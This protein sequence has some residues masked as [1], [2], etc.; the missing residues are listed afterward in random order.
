MSDV[1]A[2]EIISY[3]HDSFPGVAVVQFRLAVPDVR[4]FENVF[5][6]PGAPNIGGIGVKFENKFGE[7]CFIPGKKLF[8][9]Q[10]AFNNRETYLIP[11][12]KSTLTVVFSRPEEGTHDAFNFADDGGR[13]EEN[14]GPV[15]GGDVEDGSD[16]LHSAGV[17]EAPCTPGMNSFGDLINKGLIVSNAKTFCT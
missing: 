16:E 10:S 8:E 12:N 9:A 13:Q 4:S 14:G 11:S 6:C 17:G 15:R 3:A 1:A 2:H 5:L 7:A